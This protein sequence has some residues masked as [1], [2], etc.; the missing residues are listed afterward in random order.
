MALNG[1][2]QKEFLLIGQHID[3]TRINCF[4][5]L[6]T[7]NTCCCRTNLYRVMFETKKGN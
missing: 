7:K 2:I 3:W 5:V 1:L 4:M 6:I